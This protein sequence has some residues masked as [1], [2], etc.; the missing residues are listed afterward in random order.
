M[1]LT[2]Y[3]LQHYS[4]TSAKGYL[5]HI[6]QYQ[7]F[8]AERAEQATYTEV[9]DYI[10]TLRQQKLHPKTLRNHLFAIK[11]YYRYLLH[12]GQ[13]QDH[14]CQ[15]LY[16]K[17]Q[18]NRAIPVENLYSKAA[19]EKLYATFETPKDNRHENLHRSEKLWQAICK[20]NKII[21][22]LLIYQALTSTEVVEL[23]VAAINLEAATV[24]IQHPTYPSR[25]T[26]KDRTLSLHPKQMLLFDDY[27]KTH[28]PLLWRQQKPRKR[29][30]YFILNENGG[31]LWK[32]YLN[33]MLSKG[34]AATEVF[35]P[36]KIRQSVIAHLVK[37][38]HDIRIV[39][40]FAGHRRTASTEAYQ[41]TGL[42]ELK[43]AIENLHPLQ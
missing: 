5:H 15:H 8:M 1:T 13:R 40:E 10:G 23:R 19:L 37:E 25:Q 6:R 18:I 42:E 26:Y 24:H 35:T 9:V 4:P 31:Q 30:D 33:R 20:R 3:I 32:S 41:Q 2:T 11:I 36:F 7:L 43:T 27:L 39:Q 12:L 17:D 14:P 21:L 38:K 22:S 29:L 28:R 16:L 34:R